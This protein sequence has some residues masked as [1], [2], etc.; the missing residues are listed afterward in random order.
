MGSTDRD[1]GPRGANLVGQ[2]AQVLEPGVQMWWGENDQAPPPEAESDDT[3]GGNES[4]QQDGEG[5]IIDQIE[6][7][8]PIA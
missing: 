4:G 2:L 8:I 3:A 5:S 6:S 7:V 1:A